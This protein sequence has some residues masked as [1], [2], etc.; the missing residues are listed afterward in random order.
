[1]SNRCVAVLGRPDSPTDAVEEYCRYL[2][3]AL[4]AQ[5]TSLQIARL[6]WAETGWRTAIEELSE[7]FPSQDNSWFLLQYTALAWSRRGF[8]WRFVSVLRHLKKRGARCAVVFH[9]AEAYFGTRFVDR[10]RRAVQLRTMSNASR[11]ADLSIFTIPPEKIPWIVAPSQKTVFIPVG[12]NL[13]SPELGWQKTDAKSTAAPTV[14]VFSLSEGSVGAGEV[15]QLADAA[16]F[17]AERIGPLR[18]LVLGRNS[19]IART[20]LP[21]RLGAAPVQVI[22]HGL[23]PAEEVVQTL[24]SCDAM[25]FV[26]GQLSTRRGSAIAGI[27]CGL[28][29]IARQGGET[30]PPVT[31]A[32]IEFVRPEEA[33]NFGP[34]LVRVLADSSLRARLAKRSREAYPRY[35]SWDV[36]ASQFAEAMQKYATKLNP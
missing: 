23:L 29:V 12:P 2:A 36:I 13:A 30:A 34:A 21:E 3:S 8:S 31:E 5:G 26:R 17:A 27:A 32:G 20:L 19:E 16:R 11:L 4:A 14:V 10:A 24:G 7:K 6:G 33:N 22:V 28:P 1:M 15:R 35:F 18:I 25:L 9:D